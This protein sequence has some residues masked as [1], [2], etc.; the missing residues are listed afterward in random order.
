[1]CEVL[2]LETMPVFVKELNDDEASMVMVDSNIQRE[3]IRP[4]EKAKA[5]SMKYEAM[6]HQGKKGSGTTLDEVGENAGESGK[7]PEDDVGGKR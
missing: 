4:S 1:M 5:Y 3:N 6:K 7:K 2:G